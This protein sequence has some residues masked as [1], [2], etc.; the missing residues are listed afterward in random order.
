MIAATLMNL[1]S[2][3]V[4]EETCRGLHD[5]GF[6][7]SEMSRIG[8]CKETEKWLPRAEEKEEWG[9]TACEYWISFWDKE[10]VLK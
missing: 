7:L 1:K 9:V 4:Y 2:I 6:H 5:V 8:K 3:T 10:D